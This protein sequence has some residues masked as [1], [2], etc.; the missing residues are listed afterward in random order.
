M[1]FIE[2]LRAAHELYERLGIEPKLATFEDFVSVGWQNDSTEENILR[3]T[4]PTAFLDRRIWIDIGKKTASFGGR[5]YS[6]PVAAPPPT[7]MPKPD[8]AA[9]KPPRK[10][11][12]ITLFFDTETDGMLRFRDADDHPDQPRLLQ[13]AMILADEQKVWAEVSLLVHAERPVPDEVFKIHGISEALSKRYG[14]VPQLAAAMFNNLARTADQ[15]VCHNVDFDIRIMK[16]Q[17]AR[18]KRDVSDWNSKPTYCT[19]KKA[20]PVLRISSDRGGF[21]WPKLQEAYKLLVDPAGFEG[22]HDALADVRACRAVYNKLIEG[23]YV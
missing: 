13:I 15:I 22:A 8:I 16:A 12:M 2:K 1:I 7:S 19:M 6:L 17:F 4:Q 21:K 18:M 3:G 20:T 14:V 11:T 5:K 23:G 10:D 9:P